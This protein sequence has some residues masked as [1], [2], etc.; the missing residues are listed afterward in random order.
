M[1][2]T[3]NPSQGAPHSTPQA[4]LPNAQFNQFLVLFH[5]L[6][7]GLLCWFLAATLYWNWE[8]LGRRELALTLLLGAQAALYVKRF[9]LTPLQLSP[10]WWGIYFAGGFLCCLMESLLA[11]EF[12]WLAAFYVAPMCGILPARFAI[13]TT[14][15]ALAGL[16]FAAFGQRGLAERS[17][18]VWVFRLCILSQ[19][20]I[21]PLFTGKIVKTSEQRAQLIA[22][23]EAAKRELELARDREVEL[24]T[25]HERERLARELHDNLGHSLVT[26]TVQLEAVHR[27]LATD[28]ERVPPLLQDMQTL[29]RGSM[30]DLRRSLANLR[31]PGLGGRS[32]SEALQA[33]CTAANKP[34]GTAVKCQLAAGTERLPVAV[35]EVLWRVAQEGLTNIEKHAQAQHAEVNLAFEPTEVVLRVSDDGIGMAPGGEERPGHYGLRGLRERVEGLGGTFTATAASKGTVAEARVPMIA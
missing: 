27:L 33:L 3:M 5:I 6:T 31:A 2:A 7:V 26:L 17:A 9:I 24:A 13:P 19:W 8:H 34:A 28:P 14:I 29:T 22:E 23:L 1:L 30:E 21:M 32:L 10:L 25:L 12:A 11:P 18:G 15:A 16:E 20:I 4:P 35:A